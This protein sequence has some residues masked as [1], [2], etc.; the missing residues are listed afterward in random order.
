[1]LRPGR[2]TPGKENRYP[3]YSRLC[4]PQ[5]RSGPVRKILPLPGLDP[6]TVH[7]LQNRMP[8]LKSEKQLNA[9]LKLGVMSNLYSGQNFLTQLLSLKP[10]P[11]RLPRISLLI[12]QFCASYYNQSADLDL[13]S[14]LSLSRLRQTLLH[15]GRYL[16]VQC[17]LFSVLRMNAIID[18]CYPLVGCPTS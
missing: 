9:V 3:F 14:H 7:T 18:C 5:D 1:M 8:T 15:C 10:P 16:M 6:R 13:T 17:L 4:A 12:L 2:F 11:P